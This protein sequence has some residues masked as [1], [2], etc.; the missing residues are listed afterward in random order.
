M[1]TLGRCL[2]PVMQNTLGKRKPGFED[3][4]NFPPN[5]LSTHILIIVGS[6]YD[7]AGEARRCKTLEGLV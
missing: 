5:A 7:K 1:D 4:L 6:K 2:A 3:A